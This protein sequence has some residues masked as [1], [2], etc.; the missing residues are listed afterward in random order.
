MGAR[1]NYKYGA[2]QLNVNSKDGKVVINPTHIEYKLPGEY[3]IPKR[4]GKL[5]PSKMTVRDFAT[6]GLPKL[7]LIKDLTDAEKR[8]LSVYELLT[9]VEE[10]IT[11]WDKM[12]Y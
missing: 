9:T 7:T 10:F 11:P 1:V 8:K 12:T 4:Q 3:V 2:A 6:G 5:T